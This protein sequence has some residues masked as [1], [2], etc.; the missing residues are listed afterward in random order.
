MPIWKPILG[1]SLLCSGSNPPQPP[2]GSLP[3]GVVT[4]S[5]V[6]LT[7]APLPVYNSVIRGTSI[8]CGPWF[9]H[10]SDGR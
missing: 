6:T 1:A 9:S 3:S 4:P 10:P 8:Y 2:V 7:W 5:V